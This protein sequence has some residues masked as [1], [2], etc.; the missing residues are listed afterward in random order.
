MTKDA[1][2]SQINEALGLASSIG[3]LDIAAVAVGG[4]A[5]AV[6]RFLVWHWSMSQWPRHAHLATLSVNAMGSLCLGLLTGWVAT[7][8]IPDWAHRGLAIG[9]LGALT[10][11]STFALEAVR[12]AGQHRL[13][14]ALAYV[15]VSTF[16][17]IFL[18]WSGYS[19]A[20]G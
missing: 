8:S 16:A 3:V 9:A 12:L 5:G 14:T 2:T 1:S 4:A 11:Y 15:L 6:A 10:T 7:R 13:W 19:I 17:C 18:A 20:R